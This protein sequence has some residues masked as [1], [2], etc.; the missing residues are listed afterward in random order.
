MALFTVEELREVVSVKVLAGETPGWM[1][2]RIRHLSL[3]SRSV[4]P[5]D[6]FVAIKGDRFDGHD[7]VAAAL[8]RGAVGAIVHDAFHMEPSALK[9]G[10]RKTQPFILGARDPLFAYQ[11]LATHHRS[12]FEIPV[13]AVTGS[14]GKTTTKDMVAS[15]MAHRWKILKTEGNLNNRIGVPQTLFRLNARHEGAVIEMGVDNLGQTTRLCEIVRPTIGI[16]TNI[17][18]DHLEFFGSMDGSAQ[19]KAELLDLL[20]SDGTAVLNRDDPYY[21]Y[22]ASRARCR[23]ISFGFSSRADVRATDVKSDARDGTVFRLLLPGKVR[24]IIVHIR[25]QGAHNVTNALAAAAVGSVLG[26]PGAVIAQGLARF[27]PAAMRSQIVVSQGVKIINDCY[28]A[29]PASMKAAVQLLAQTEG[30]GRKIAVLGDMLELGPGAATM[31]EEV[32]GFAARQGI[33]RIVACGPLA[34]S[35]AEGARR[36]GMDKDRIVEV[37]DAAGAAAVKDLIKPGDVVLVKGSRGMKLEQV[38]QALQAPKRA[39]KQ[40]S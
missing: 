39:A 15:V 40:A 17:G 11:Q 31:H 37:P 34:R 18:P 30:A 19:A 25:V 21:D 36:A 35:L 29:N 4:K 13:V 22:L 9:S 2:Q 6:V 1:K 23:V 28:N 27:R 7:F 24:H 12:R 38:V 33:D 20:P 32:G 8:T 10:P 5:G 14:N 26:L 3:D 16:I